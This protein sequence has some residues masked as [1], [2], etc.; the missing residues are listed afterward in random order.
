MPCLRLLAILLLSC[1]V[2]SARAQTLIA[3]DNANPPFMYQQDGQPR[4]LYPLLLQA[5]FARLGEPLAIQAMPW[6]RALLRGAA[7]ELGI[8]GIYKNAERFRVFDYSAPIFEERLLLYVHREKPLPF[9]SIEDLHG[10]RIGVIRGWSYTEEFDQAARTGQIDAQEGSSDEA[11]LRKLA[12][13]RLDAVIAIELAGQRLLTHAG[14]EQLEPL[15]QPLSINPTYLVFARQ[16]GQQEL[17]QRFDR[18]L[19]E[20]RQDGSLQRLIEQAIATP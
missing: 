8:G 12:S 4:G 20:M 3:I 6:K 16:A 9:R 19:A 18:T 10:K 14:L 15:P 13:G 17:L 5:V 1:S 2:L 11:N 7:G